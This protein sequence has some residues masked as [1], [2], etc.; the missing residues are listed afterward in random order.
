[1]KKQLFAAMM[2][3]A[4]LCA[5]AFT[6]NT[7][8][9]Y[10][11]ENFAEG[12]VYRGKDYS[13]ARFNIHLLGNVL[14]YINPDDDKIYTAKHSDMDSVVIAGKKFVQ[15]PVEGKL[16]E[17]LAVS[18]EN[19]VLKLEY[20][21]FNVLAANSGAYG[22]SLNSSASNNWASLDLA[23]MNTPRHGLMLQERNDGSD[24]RMRAKYY[25][26]IGSR[27]VAA[28]KGD[29]EDLLPAERKDEWKKFLKENKIKWK[30]PESLAVVLGFFK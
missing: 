27:C 18:G 5:N 19:L 22:A 6:P 26:L 3:V 30:N 23:G 20:A 24:L 15:T 16:M 17:V 29:V 25:L 4:A 7:K 21:D 13:M 12:T 11:N 14:H 9:P 10:L 2:A 28:N 8:W 1:M